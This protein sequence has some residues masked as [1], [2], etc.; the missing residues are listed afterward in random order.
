MLTVFKFCQWTGPD[1]AERPKEAWSPSSSPHRRSSSSMD[2]FTINF[3][4]NAPVGLG[5]HHATATATDGHAST[6]NQTAGSS[7]LECVVSD[8]LPDSQ[9]AA[10][11]AQCRANGDIAR[12]LAANV[13]VVSKIN[14]R[15]MRG[16]PYLQVLQR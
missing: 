3:H 2:E 12:L 1:A 15:D 16:V 9:A 4:G 11:N 10:H 7:T 8:V 5:F 14:G 13:S 6:I